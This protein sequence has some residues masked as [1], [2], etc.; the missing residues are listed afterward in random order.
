MFCVHAILAMSAEQDVLVDSHV[1]VVSRPPPPGVCHYPIPEPTVTIT[2]KAYD[3][4][5][6][7][8]NSVTRPNG[9]IDQRQAKESQEELQGSPSRDTQYE[10]EGRILV[11]PDGTMRVCPPELFSPYESISR[12]DFARSH[13]CPV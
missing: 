6:A 7:S 8:C 1:I 9:D 3:Q 4:L 13:C 5:I 10:L 12:H 2:R 11:D